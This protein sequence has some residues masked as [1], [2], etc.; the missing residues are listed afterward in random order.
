MRNKEK[1]LKSVLGE[2]TTSMEM[3]ET[4]AGRL[5]SMKGRTEG[6]KE[7]REGGRGGK[8]GND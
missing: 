7:G 1:D 6:W 3:R 8:E 2:K 4:E 5:S